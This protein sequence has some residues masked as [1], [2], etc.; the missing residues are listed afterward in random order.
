MRLVGVRKYRLDWRRLR[1]EASQGEKGRNRRRKRVKRR[2]TD[3][4]KR[5]PATDLTKL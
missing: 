5:Y 4:E 3:D 1:Q 2:N